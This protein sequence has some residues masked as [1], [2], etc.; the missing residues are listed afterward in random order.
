M[1]CEEGARN[2]TLYLDGTLAGEA[3]RRY[4]LHLDGCA[5]CRQE[6]D[7]WIRLEDLP[8][9]EPNSVRMRRALDRAVA[10]EQWRASRR[11]VPMPW[12]GWAAAAMV[13]LASGWLLGR[14][15]GAGR[16]S[17]PPR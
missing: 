3:R 6:L 7:L 16:L 12:Y 10:A 11:P 2:L 4:E 15:T 5:D 9:A 13:L 17:E 14:S 8:E 1:S